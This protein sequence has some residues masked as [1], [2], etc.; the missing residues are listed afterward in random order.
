MEDRP[1]EAAASF[2]LN[3]AS[4]VRKTVLELTL[5]KAVQDVHAR[6]PL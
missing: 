3:Y 6:L 1:T 2:K 4:V 5:L